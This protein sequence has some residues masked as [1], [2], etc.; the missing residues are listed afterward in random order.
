[1]DQIWFLNGTEDHGVNIDSVQIDLPTI[2]AQKDKDVFGFAR[3]I[4]DLFT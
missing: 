2:L 4:E 1:M 3:G